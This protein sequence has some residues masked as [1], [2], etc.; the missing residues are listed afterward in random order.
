M[1]SITLADNEPETYLEGPG[2]FDIQ[3]FRTVPP[4]EGNELYYIKANDL[5]FEVFG[6]ATYPNDIANYFYQLDDQDWIDNDQMIAINIENISEGYHKIRAKAVDSN[7]VEDPTPA[8]IEFFVD[9]VRPSP[10]IDSGPNGWIDERSVVFNFS[11]IDPPPGSEGLRFSYRLDS[12][13]WIEYSNITSATF[14]NLAEGLHTFWL[15]VTDAAGNE[16]FIYRDFVVN[17][18][19]PPETKIIS[20]PASTISTKTT[21]FE[22]SGS[23]NLTETSDLTY[24]YRI[25]GDKWQAFTYATKLILEKLLPG[26]YV[27]EVQ[28]RDQS[29]NIDPTPAKHVFKVIVQISSDRLFLIL[30]GKKT[31]NKG[32]QN[33]LLTGQLT[34]I[35]GKAIQNKR[36]TIK[37]KVS[38]NANKKKKAL[39]K[40]HYQ[41]YRALFKKTKN[42]KIKNRYKKLTAKYKKT[43]LKIKIVFWKI[44]TRVKTDSKGQFVKSIR[45][46]TTTTYQAEFGG[47]NEYKKTSSNLLKASVKS[48]KKKRK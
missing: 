25:N 17:D 35:Y 46:K 22:Y 16:S 44:I 7:N 32:R 20:G 33:L 28:A 41:K 11:G 1:T 40:K 6:T 10:K 48:M 13:D 29:G 5:T 36:I 19:T 24:Q 2:F 31:I 8:E 47:D 18:K 38:S 43:Y 45:S 23:D 21:E 26:Q 9:T 3:E 37:A 14:N 34:D 30:S 12:A 39:Y 4:K 27:F 15:A 42:K